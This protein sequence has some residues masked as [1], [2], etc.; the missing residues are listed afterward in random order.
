LR[1]ISAL[2]VKDRSKSNAQKTPKEKNTL[3]LSKKMLL[4]EILNSLKEMKRRPLKKKYKLEKKGV[5]SFQQRGSIG[6]RN[7]SKLK[8]SYT[9]MRKKFTQYGDSF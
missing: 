9:R 4:K 1:K 2:S 7:I 5:V 3:K 6:F 8:L